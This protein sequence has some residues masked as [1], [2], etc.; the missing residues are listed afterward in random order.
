[1]AVLAS[2]VA[3]MGFEILAGRLVTPAFGSSVYTWGA[4]IGVFLTALSLGYAIGGRH[5]SERAS[6]DTL[7]L[8][9]GASAM[10]VAVLSVGGEAVIS[11]SEGLPV[12]DRYAAILPVT[13]LFGPLTFLLGLISPYAAELADAESQGS[14][15]GWVY[16]L[17][18]IGSIAGTF[19]TTFLLIP[20]VP[21]WQVEL[22][23][24][25]S[26]VVAAAYVGLRTTSA[27]SAGVVIVAACL[28]ILA[29]ATSV[30]ALGG[31]EVVYET[32]TAYSD[33]RI[34]DSDGVR[35]MYLDGV[36]QSATYIDGRE[37]YVFGYSP[38]THIPLLM[39][40]DVENVLVIGGG[41]FST[42]KRYVEEYDVTVD[43]VEIDPQVVDAAKTYF[44][45]SESD[46]L[47]IH[48]QDGRS[49]L[50]S[51]DT[52]Y[53]VVIL[54]A[55]RKDQVPFHLTTQEFMQLVNDRLD[56]DGTLMANIISARSG[57]GSAFYRAMV[58]TMRTEFPHVYSFPT[59]DT[60]ALQNIE[61]VAS[62]R[63][64]G[65]SEADLRANNDPA[66]IGLDLSAQISR[67]T[68]TDEIP[69]DDVPVLTDDYAPTER[70]LGEQAGKQY[71]ITGYN[72]STDTSESLAAP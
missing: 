41:G 45:V 67:Y 46:D 24:G 51:T 52:T 26:L 40:D 5:A 49:F 59:A 50:E 64:E 38:Y 43:V 6:N 10:L 55:F 9:L 54:D 22:L 57:Q 29:G 1:V 20:Y 39:Q 61:L 17:G 14:A 3:S 13:V 62:K 71:V 48:V 7:V 63:A 15:S 28:L 47:R 56:S 34:T 66:R 23:L 53:D 70:L 33:L 31:S 4:T 68:P 16:A 65:Y 12:A 58:K 27:R 18:T 60:G 36:P 35:T 72:G 25:G 30:V 19:A 8:V 32:Q 2:G 21:I 11:L 42:P 37:G 69:T 44:N